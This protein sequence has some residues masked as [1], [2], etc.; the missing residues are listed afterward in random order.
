MLLNVETWFEH[1]EKHFRASRIA[2]ERRA[3]LF[4]YHTDEE[5]PGVMRAMHVQVTDDYDGLKSALFE[6]F[7]V[8]T[9][10]ERFSAEFFRRKQQRGESVRIYAG[11]SRWLF[12]KAYSPGRAHL[13]RAQQRRTGGSGAAV[14]AAADDGHPCGCKESDSPAATPAGEERPQNVLDMRKNGPH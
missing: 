1:L 13:E 9:G 7:G 2:P 11:H 12:T 10:S 14:E 8:R 4:Q 3:S 5:V 6:A